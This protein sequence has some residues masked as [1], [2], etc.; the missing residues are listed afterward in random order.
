MQLVAAAVASGLAAA[1]CLLM[2]MGSWQS[3]MQVQPQTQHSL[4]THGTA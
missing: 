3:S 2:L 4:M 1:A